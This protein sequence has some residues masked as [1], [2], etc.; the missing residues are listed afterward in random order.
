LDFPEVTLTGI[1]AADIGLHFPDFRA[2]ERT[3]GLLTQAAG[4]S[5]RARPGEAI[6]Q[7]YAPDHPAI[8][9]AAAYDYEGFARQELEERRA[10]R[11]P[12]FGRLVYLGII[13]R[14]REDAEACAK[15]YA[16]LVRALPGVEVLGPAPFPVARMND[17]WRYR[18][19][20]KTPEIGTVCTFI[21]EHLQK[22]AVKDRSIRLLVNIDP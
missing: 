11:Y 20:V 1:V 14:R 9:F 19:A 21:R 2:S 17:E 10:L 16:A 5:G 22:I 6:V 7:T 15:K 13:G 12:P 4:R 18:V 3:F 8:R